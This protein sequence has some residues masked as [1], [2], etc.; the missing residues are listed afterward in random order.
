MREQ[1]FFY[2]I[3]K[4]N[5]FLNNNIILHSL[6]YR[7]DD[8]NRDERKWEMKWN[9]FIESV[10]SFKLQIKRNAQNE[11]QYFSFTDFYSWEIWI[12]LFF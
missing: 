1:L 12:N 10:N 5:L 9:S 4:K 11:I 8:E 6:A 2:I 3:Q 7:W